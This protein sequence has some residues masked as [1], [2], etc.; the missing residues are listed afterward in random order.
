MRSQW[1]RA[2]PS[3]VQPG[4]VAHSCL[5][6][7]TGPPSWFAAIITETSKY[8]CESINCPMERSR[9]YLMFVAVRNGI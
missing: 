9:C 7:T 6:F 5:K 8:N 3:V 2:I 4:D 1:P